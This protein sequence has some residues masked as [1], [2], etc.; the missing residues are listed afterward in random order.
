MSTDPAGRQI[1]SKGEQEVREEKEEKEPIYVKGGEGS[2][3]YL[4]WL[5]L[6]SQAKLVPVFGVC[7][8][9]NSQK[10]HRRMAS[11]CWR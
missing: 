7:D 11:L 8:N 6:S 1:V 3:L 2:R 4:A 10:M 5:S 9:I